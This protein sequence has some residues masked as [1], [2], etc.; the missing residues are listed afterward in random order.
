MRSASSLLIEWQPPDLE[1]ER[2]EFF[3]HP[4]KQEW[5]RK[6]EVSWERL[7]AAFPDGELVAYPRAARL[8][9]FPVALSYHSYDDYL[10]YLARAKRGYRVNYT[11]LEQALQAEGSLLLKAPIVLAAGGEALLFS[12]WRRLCLAW[13]YGMVPAVWLVRLPAAPS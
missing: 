12:G 1:E 2:W 6:H 11:K 9:Q 7:A 5:Y 10:T 3:Q 4:A 8:L 13:N